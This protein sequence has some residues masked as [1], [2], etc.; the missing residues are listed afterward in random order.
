M[1]QHIPAFF[2]LFLGSALPL[3]GG[4]ENKH[5]VINK[6]ATKDQ[7]TC[8]ELFI[9]NDHVKV[10]ILRYQ[11]NKPFPQSV[12][13]TGPEEEPCLLQPFRS[14]PANIASCELSPCGLFATITT[15]PEDQPALH[16]NPKYITYLFEIEPIFSQRILKG[17]ISDPH[18]RAQELAVWHKKDDPKSLSGGFAVLPFEGPAEM[19]ATEPI[20]NHRLKAL[21][22]LNFMPRRAK[23]DSTPLPGSIEPS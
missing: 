21:T 7:R 4:G 14:L 13:V 1:K 11:P 22:A 18:P 3:R 2:L 12:H 6:I 15:L 23:L 9:G 19:V 17:F 5:L 8:L 20:D 16:I 10:E